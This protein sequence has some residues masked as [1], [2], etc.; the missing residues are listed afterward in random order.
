MQ[1]IIG[2]HRGDSDENWTRVQV[3][4]ITRDDGHGL[5]NDAHSLSILNLAQP[6]D[7][8]NTVS[9]ACLPRNAGQDYAGQNATVT[10]WGIKEDVTRP[11][12]LQEVNVTVI[13]NEHCQDGWS[14]TNPEFD[15]S[16][17]ISEYV[18]L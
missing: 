12:V 8:D 16:N 3:S 1:V 7:F 5:S 4:S 18:D 2:A 6:V 9:P 13:T 11:S 10:G 17:D 15:H 14:D